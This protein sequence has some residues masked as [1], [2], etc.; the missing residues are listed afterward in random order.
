MFECQF[1]IGTVCNGINFEIYFNFEIFYINGNEL[2]IGVEM[3]L[4][5]EIDSGCATVTRVVDSITSNGVCV[6]YGSSSSGR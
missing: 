2:G 5:K 4:L 6:R 1:Y 3:M